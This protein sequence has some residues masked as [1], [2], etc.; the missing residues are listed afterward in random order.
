MSNKYFRLKLFAGRPIGIPEEVSEDTIA[1]LDRKVLD[2]GT[3]LLISEYLY[4]KE[5]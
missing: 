1:A 2:T 4:W 5:D 3:R